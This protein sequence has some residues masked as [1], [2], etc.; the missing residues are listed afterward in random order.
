MNFPG[1]LQ[2]QSYSWGGVPG[3]GTALLMEKMT[4]TTLGK[5]CVA[6]TQTDQRLGRQPRTCHLPIAR[7]LNIPYLTSCSTTGRSQNTLSSQSLTKSQQRD[8]SFTSILSKNLWMV[9]YSK[10]LDCMTSYTPKQKQNSDWV[11]HVVH[12]LKRLSG[13]VSVINTSHSLAF[14]LYSD[15]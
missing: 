2:K 13:M 5:G 10:L 12:I 8:L 4:T 1:E 15:K 3:I 6:E 11:I 9:S 14:L 7:N